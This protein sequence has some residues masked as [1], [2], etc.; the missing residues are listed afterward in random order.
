MNWV[1]SSVFPKERNTAIAG[2][3]PGEA[4]Q[5][6]N[7]KRNSSCCLTPP[8]AA[9]NAVYGVPRNAIG[10]RQKPPRY[11]EISE[12]LSYCASLYQSQ[13]VPPVFLTFGLPALIHHVLHIDFAIA[14]EKVIW[15]DTGRVVA[16]ME[17]VRSFWDW[18]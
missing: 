17:N 5:S 8:L 13:F 6:L 12:D 14:K 9:Y 10:I 16:V 1:S 11:T 7:R 4:V 15:I 2:S 3:R 18:S